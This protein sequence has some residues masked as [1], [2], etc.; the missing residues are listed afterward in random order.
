MAK[1]SVKKDDYVMIIAG[2]DKGK[3]AKVLAIDTKKQGGNR[4]QGH[5]HNKESGKGKES[6]R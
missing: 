3:T 4:R 5:Y 6:V 2:K 1:L